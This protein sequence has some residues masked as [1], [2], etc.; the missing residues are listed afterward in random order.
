MR[1][2]GHKNLLN[3]L[4]IL[5]VEKVSVMGQ[6]QPLEEP[7]GG[8]GRR[9]KIR[10]PPR[11]ASPGLKGPP[12]HG[13]ARTGSIYRD[14]ICCRSVALDDVSCYDISSRGR[15]GTGNRDRPE[16]WR[17]SQA[18]ARESRRPGTQGRFARKWRLLARV[19]RGQVRRGGAR[20]QIETCKPSV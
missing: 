7:Q 16:F 19:L 13:G 15:L 4:G 8:T 6:R 17:G 5:L 14:A 1:T 9:E 10:V 3:M 2:T 12:S 18:L 11:R 20:Y